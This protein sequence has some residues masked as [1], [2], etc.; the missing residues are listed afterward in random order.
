MLVF[1]GLPWVKNVEKSFKNEDKHMKKTLFILTTLV[2][3][4]LLALAS[5]ASGA[6]AANLPASEPAPEWVSDPYTRFNRQLYLAAV[7]SGNSR[8]VAERDA[9]GRLVSIFGQ[10]IQV[11]QRVAES[12]WE[13]VGSGAAASWTQTT[14]IDSAIVTS[15][16]MDTLIGAEIGDVWEDGRG[17][18]FAVAVLNIPRTRQIYSQMLRANLEI[19]DGLTGMPPAQ[20]NSIDGL[21]RYQFAAV[22]ADMNVSHGAVLSVIGAPHYAQ[23][24]RSGDDFRRQ[25]NEIARGI[26]VGINVR[27]DMAGRIESAF[28]GVF[29]GLGFNTGG[30]N[31]RYLLDVDVINQ[32][33]DQARQDVA[34]TRLEV[35]ANFIDTSN[36][37]TLLPFNFNL[38]EGHRNLSEA[39]NRAF[40]SAERR[41]SN[42]YRDILSAYMSRLNPR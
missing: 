32:P 14:T 12:Y 33:V 39:N 24:L 2:A 16:R 37:T 20:R 36:G 22:I 7:G 5:C 34:F 8:A 15:A 26:P 35:T 6:G 25:A 13:A 18:S 27:G 11:D 30:A 4:C 31:P 3:M 21:S 10:S 23:G 1:A 40:A 17:N 19:I 42:E 9:I 29:S 41:I 28:A 38:R